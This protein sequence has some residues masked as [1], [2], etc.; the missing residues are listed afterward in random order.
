MSKQASLHN[1]GSEQLLLA[2]GAWM[3]DFSCHMG[4]EKRRISTSPEPKSLRDLTE[5]ILDVEWNE[6]LE[7]QRENMRSSGYFQERTVC[8]KV[9]EWYPTPRCLKALNHVHN[10][11]E[12]LRPSWAHKKRTPPLFGDPSENLLHRKGVL[13]VARKLTKLT[14]VKKGRMELYPPTPIGKAMPDI[15]VRP[16]NLH[17]WVV[18][19]ACENNDVARVAQK[20]AYLMRSDYAVWVVVENRKTAAKIFNKLHDENFIEWHGERI[21]TRRAKNWPAS[22]MNEKLRK[23]VQPTDQSE[24]VMVQGITGVIDADPKRVGGWLSETVRYVQN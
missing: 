1:W 17:P 12:N 3:N 20:V 14:P 10:E 8:R 16:E 24:L 13:S 19:V 18:E 5:G 11:N 21:Q 2:I 7:H 22:A 6:Q 9:I 15:I 4:S 23:T